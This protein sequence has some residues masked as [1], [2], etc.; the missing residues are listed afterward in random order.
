M[1][2][3]ARLI[4]FAA[5]ADLA[6]ARHFYQG[7]LGLAVLDASPTVLVIDCGGTMLRISRVE[8]P[9][10]APYTVLGWRVVDIETTVGQLRD[11]GVK[12]ERFPGFPHGESG[13]MAFPN[14]DRVAWF[15]DPDGN[16]LSLTQFAH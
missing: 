15:K 16:L 6:R 11:A 8:R 3:D 7:T 12:F 13:I 4:G 2:K 1:L 14:G 9:S 10:I 5:S